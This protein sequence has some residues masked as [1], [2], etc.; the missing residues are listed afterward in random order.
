LTPLSIRE[1]YTLT[2]SEGE[3]AGLAYEYFVKRSLLSSWLHR[4]GFRPKSNNPPRVLIAGLPETVGSGL[5]FLLLTQELG[6][7]PLVVDE[8]PAAFDKLT[9]AVETA[10]RFGKLQDARFKGVVVNDMGVIWE[11]AA[12]FDLVLSS[13]V[14]Q[15]LDNSTQAAYLTHL[16]QIGKHIALFAPNDDNKLFLQQRGTLGV[17]RQLLARSIDIPSL[18]TD[19]AV[20][21]PFG[22][23]VSLSQL[24]QE[25]TISERLEKIAFTG[26]QLAAWV[27]R[28]SPIELRQSRGRLVYALGDV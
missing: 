20:M 27:D 25:N 19:Y 12:D 3:G 5:D 22:S 26:L 18:I 16:R 1:L 8:R 15:R 10:Q 17:E 24:I 7:T 21:P 13:H 23:L 4:G 14:I 9:H 11:A 6:A 2:A 28:L